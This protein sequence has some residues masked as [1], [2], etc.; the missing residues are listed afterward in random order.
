M[1]QSLGTTGMALNPIHL[2]VKTTIDQ[3]FEGASWCYGLGGVGQ[4]VFGYAE[5]F[6]LLQEDLERA[7]TELSRI[8]TGVSVQR[9]ATL[10]LLCSHRFLCI[11]RL[12]CPSQEEIMAKLDA[13][14]V[15][16]K[17]EYAERKAA[18]A[19]H[20]QNI[21]DRLGKTKTEANPDE[22]LLSELSKLS[23]ASRPDPNPVAS[24]TL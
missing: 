15:D 10:P 24:F 14:E 23:K 3:H 22:A 6:K 9:Q 7:S 12:L 8:M 20:Q 16:R 11:N 2:Q 5:K 18:N 17:R 1:S 21:L 4:A 19:T 13:Q